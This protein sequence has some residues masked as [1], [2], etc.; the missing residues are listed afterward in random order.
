MKISDI[1][2]IDIFLTSSSFEE[3]CFTIIN[4]IE[5]NEL[6]PS[7]TFIFYNDNEV[8]SIVDNAQT[9]SI[10]L[11]NSELVNL[12]SDTPTANYIKIRKLL[13]G[14]AQNEKTLSILIDITT[15][16][17]ETLLIILKILHLIRQNISKIYLTYSGAKE[18]STADKKNEDKWLSKGIK[19]IRN[20]IGYPGFHD[21]M[22][23][24]H[25]IILFGFEFERTVSLIEK[26]E[27][28]ILSLG[29]CDEQTAIASGHF[30]INRDRHLK[31]LDKYQNSNQFIFSL[32][33]PL[34]TKDEI[35]E[36]IT[37]F[38]LNG[39][40]TV[41]APMN[42]KISTIGVGLS[43]FQNPN[44]QL[45]YAKPLIY[46]TSNYSIP[47]NKIYVNEIDLKNHS[48]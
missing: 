28:D 8:R 26:F 41:I 21:R 18:Y 6:I 12:N 31:L 43:A 36:H 19:D 42:N 29:F 48:V 2:Q 15:F 25:L 35:L 9:L 33:N 22:R 17:H 45:V 13:F 32:T 23:T 46:N 7:S 10:K 39:A 40:N 38:D 34:K 37:K 5:K 3:R 11:P 16:T 20:I 44:I 14:L 24:N 30:K 1:E 4:E 47:N 27:Y